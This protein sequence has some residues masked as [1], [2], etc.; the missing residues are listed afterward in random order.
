MSADELT[1]SQK[2]LTLN[3]TS[4]RGWS[5]IFGLEGGLLSLLTRSLKHGIN[6]R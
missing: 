1:L 2:S 5:G 6:A 3:P 4:G